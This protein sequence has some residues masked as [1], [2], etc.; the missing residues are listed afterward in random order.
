MPSPHAQGIIARRGQLPEAGREKN[1]ISGIQARA[2]GALRRDPTRESVRQMG[3]G[4]ADLKQDNAPLR[5]VPP[6][7]TPSPHAQGIIARKGQ[8]SKADRGDN[9]IYGIQAWARGALRRDPTEES[10]RQMGSGQAGLK[11]ESVRQEG[12]K[13]DNT[14]PHSTSSPH[15]QGIIARRGRLPEA[16]RGDNPIHGIRPERATGRRASSRRES[17]GQTDLKQDNTPP[18]SDASDSAPGSLL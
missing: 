8:L 9:P 12:L 13:Q 1:P 2:R 14:P 17:S 16:D 4:Q 7:S 6:H 10:A 18:Q 3:S 15:A 5:R 11:Q